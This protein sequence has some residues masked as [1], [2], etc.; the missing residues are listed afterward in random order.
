MD[1]K[2][3]KLPDH[4]IEQFWLYVKQS[5]NN[6]YSQ[7]NIIPRPIESWSTSL[8]LLQQQKRYDEIELRIKQ[9]LSLYSIDL[10]RLGKQYHINILITNLKRWDKLT[11]QYRFFD[12]VETEKNLVIVLLEI[13]YGLLKTNTDLEDLFADLELYIIYEDFTKLIRYAVEKNK[14]SILDKL[15]NYD[16]LNVIRTV[17]GLYSVNIEY[18]QYEKLCGKKIIKLI[19]AN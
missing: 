1:D 4:D 16:Y 19:L 3:Q 5:M 7:T 12:N 14:P 11:K 9:Y 8:N 17:I 15:I 18:T 13:V 2:T 6:F 10:L